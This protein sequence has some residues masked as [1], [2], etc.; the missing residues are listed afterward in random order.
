MGIV[1]KEE[2]NNGNDSCRNIQK[3]LP[4]FHAIY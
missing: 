1:E 2:I 4:L 3:S